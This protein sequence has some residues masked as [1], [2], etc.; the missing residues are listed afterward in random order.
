[1]SPQTSEPSRRRGPAALDP[2][3]DGWYVISPGAHL[4]TEKLLQKTWMG[5]EIVAWRDGRGAVCVADGFCPHL[6]SHLGPETGGAIRNGNLVCPFHGF[7]FDVT[8]RCRATPHAPPP[9]AARLRTYPVEE[10]NGF[11][12]AYWDHAGRAPTWSVPDLA[13]EGWRGRAL[14]RLRLRTHPQVTTENSVDLGHLRHIHGYGDV[15]QLAPTSIEGA[16]LTSCYSFSRHLLTRGLRRVRFAISI[17]IR[18]W[19]L[20]VSV[21]DIA[22][23]AAGLK[24]RQWVLATPI[25]GEVIDLWLA[26]DPRGRMRLPVVGSLPRWASHGVAPRIML[27]ELELDVMKDA[28]IWAH[29]RY[30]AEPVLSKGDQ[31]VYRFRR[32]SEQFYPPRRT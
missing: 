20:G 26:V 19:G 25:D 23:P 16:C 1:M 3:P 10:S 13:P 21:V 18:V 7:E 12:F 8:G 17:K 31:D 11:V 4:G 22:S 9:K 32:Y 5:Q 6:G 24:M 30:E 2:F 28:V 14:K 15:T 29:H 27:H